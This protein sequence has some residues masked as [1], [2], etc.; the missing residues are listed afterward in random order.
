MGNSWY[1]K[2]MPK[3]SMVKPHLQSIAKKI[4]DIDGVKSIYVWGSFAKNENKPNFILKD[5]DI[6]ASTDIFSEDLLS[7]TNNEINSP[8]NI[9]ATQLEDDGFDPKAVKFTKAFTSVRD[10]NVD[11]WAISK[12]EKL[13][14]WGPVPETKEDSEEIKAQAEQYAEKVTDK[15]RKQLVTASQ[16][17]KDTWSIRYDHFMNKSLS[18][19]PQGWF[20]TE[21][22]VEEILKEAKKLDE[23]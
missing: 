21:C 2:S 10:Y 13:L 8:F 23:C 16:S 15:T 3:V 14:H 19:M 1:K 7:I 5:I 17:E 11:H 18:G 22:K 12:D 6:I 9:T 20:V 4:S